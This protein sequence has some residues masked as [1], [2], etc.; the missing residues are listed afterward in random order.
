MDS[1]NEFIRDAGLI[2]VQLKNRKYTWSSKRPEP[3]FSKLDRVLTTV[4]W[5][6]SYPIIT[7]EALELVVSDHVPLVLFCRNEAT[8][9]RRHKIEIFWL[10]YEAPK[11]MVQT[12][13]SSVAT[14]P[15]A[16]LLKFHAKDRKSVV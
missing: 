13:W 16:S 12:L 3:T 5:T 7:L 8:A 15:Q 10:K 9:R 11:L 6:L 4:E 1:F 14:L 2:D